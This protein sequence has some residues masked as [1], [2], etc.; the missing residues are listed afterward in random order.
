M[1]LGCGD[2]TAGSFILIRLL[3]LVNSIGFISIDF[4]GAGTFGIL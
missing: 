4:I 1:G 2:R 3:A